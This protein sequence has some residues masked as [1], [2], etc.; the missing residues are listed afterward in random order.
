MIELFYLTHR[1]N[2]TSNLSPYDWRF[3]TPCYSDHSTPGKKPFVFK[4]WRT[5][6]AF[7]R[8][9][10]FLNST[11]IS[12]WLTSIN[13]YEKTLNIFFSNN[14]KQ[15]VEPKKHVQT[16]QWHQDKTLWP[17]YFSRQFSDWFF[18]VFV[19]LFIFLWNRFFFFFSHYFLLQ[20][21]A[22]YLSYQIYCFHTIFFV[23]LSDSVH[24]FSIS[25]IFI[26]G[27]NNIVYFLRSTQK[28]F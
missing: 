2:P 10:L 5:F 23:C 4:Y 22:Q 19:C 24:F 14:M 13:S 15:N 18:L 26:H 3:P 12:M 16:N 25:L 6:F 8:S 20:I 21:F 7:K 9:V 27:L 17:W 28:I 11:S 1:W